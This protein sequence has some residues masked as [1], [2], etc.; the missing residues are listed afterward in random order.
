MPMT[1]FQITPLDA[2]IFRDGRPFAQGEYA[3][4]MPF[5]FPSVLAGGMRSLAGAPDYRNIPQLLRIRQTGPFL[6]AGREGEPPELAVAAPADAVPY[7]LTAEMTGPI[8]LAYLQARKVAEG[9]GAPLPEPLTEL[10][11]GGRSEKVSKRMP[12]FWSWPVMENWLLRPGPR[13]A[14]PSALGPP[15]LPHSRRTHVAIL[16]KSRTADD[17][18]LFSTTGLEFQTNGAKPDGWDPWQFSLYS[19]FE[20]PVGLSGVP[21]LPTVEALGG[22]GR[23]AKWEAA[24]LRLPECPA[25]LQENE[26][27]LRRYRFVL[28]TP[29]AFAGGWCPRWLQTGSGS[30]PEQS[31]IQ[32]RLISASIPRGLPISGWDLHLKKAKASRLLVPAG[33]V[34]IVESKSDLSPLWFRSISDEEQDRLDGFGL[35]AL[36]K[37]APA[38]GDSNWKEGK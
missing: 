23:L 19:G 12:S 14:E 5:P 7:E 20:F 22:E 36:G 33:S 30:P 24:S 38:D 29:G 27:K 17:G 13:T 35:V 28:L 26:G 21:K 1:G 31:E 11:M 32:V 10:M 6:L 3:L 4:T 8:E 2:A 9:R 18:M 37:V 25:E 16:P 15:P 34:Y